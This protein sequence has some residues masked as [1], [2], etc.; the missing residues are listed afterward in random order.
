MDKQRLPDFLQRVFNDC[1]QAQLSA[2]GS[3]KRG[4]RICGHSTS[5]SLERAYWGVIETMARE[6]H[7]TVPQIIESVFLGCVVC[8]DKNVS[9]CL[10]VICLKFISEN[11]DRVDALSPAVN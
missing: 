2:Y 10:R 8:N 1:S 7:C 11:R 3:E 9:S 4:F 6:M 5:V